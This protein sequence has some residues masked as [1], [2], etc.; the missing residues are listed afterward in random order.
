M[1]KNVTYFH[2]RWKISFRLNDWRLGFILNREDRMFNIHLP[3]L[4]IV[5]WWWRETL[6]EQS[7]REGWKDAV[8]Y[9]EQCLRVDRKIHDVIASARDVG[10][11]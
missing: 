9:V 8:D 5:I 4:V 3:M 7:F 11:G 10:R 1:D 6:Q 2:W